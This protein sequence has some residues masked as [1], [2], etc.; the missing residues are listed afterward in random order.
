MLGQVEARGG[1]PR[2]PRP[3]SRGGGPGSREA[4]R[5]WPSAARRRPGPRRGGDRSRRPRPARSRD[6][7]RGEATLSARPVDRSST[8]TTSSPRATRAVAEMRAEEPRPPVTTTRR[9]APRTAPRPDRAH[10]RPDAHVGE[11]QPAH[12]GRVEQVAGVDHGRL[13]QQVADLGE[14]EPAELV[15]LGEHDDA[16]GARRTPRRRR[17]QISTARSGSSRERTRDDRWGRRPGPWRPVGHQPAHDLHGRGVAQVVGAGLEG[18]AP[19]RRPP[20]PAERSPDGRGGPWPATAVELRLVGLD[21]PPEE[22]EVVARLLG[23]CGPAPGCPWAGTS[24][25]SPG[26]GAGTRS[27]CA[28]RSPCRG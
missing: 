2:C 7:R 13:G 26:P 5:G 25:P 21:G 19:A 28:G 11:A 18:E 24:R 3:G 12:G 20:A 4:R 15:P 27:R 22:R 8:Q 9:Y 6:V 1:S 10:R 23:R 17:R 16:G 14:V